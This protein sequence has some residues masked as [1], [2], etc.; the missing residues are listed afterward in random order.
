[1]LCKRCAKNA[2]QRDGG[3][4][5]ICNRHSKTKCLICDQPSLGEEMCAV[6]TH[7]S[8]I[9]RWTA[10]ANFRR[11]E[12]ADEIDSLAIRKEGLQQA[13]F[14]AHEAVEVFF[15]SLLGAMIA[16]HGALDDVEEERKA[17]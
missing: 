10:K 4:L 11:L 15:R 6:H 3:K 8:E 1:M 16:M 9:I 5:G 2:V 14:L 17:A 7:Q 13:K 12:I